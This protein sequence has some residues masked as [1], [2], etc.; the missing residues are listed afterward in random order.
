MAKPVR[1]NG[2]GGC[3]ANRGAR[4]RTGREAAANGFS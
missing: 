3:E 1:A 2:E 4:V